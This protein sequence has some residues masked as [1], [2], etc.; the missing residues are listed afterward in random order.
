[1]RIL[2][3]V[4]GVSAMIG[5]AAPAYADPDPAPPPADDG[6]FLAALQQDGIAYPSPAQAIGSARA[7]CECLDNGETGL[8]LVEDVKTHNPGITMDEA[9][10]F[11]LLSAKYYC[12][13]HLSKA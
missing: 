11:A 6:G 9:S 7:V 13:H 5:L 1:M 10:H 2:L 4:L 3:A 8:N 12:P